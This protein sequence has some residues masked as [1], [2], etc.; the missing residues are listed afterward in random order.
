MRHLGW[1]G[2]G[3]LVAAALMAC[4][5]EELHEKPWLYINRDPWNM[6][7]AFVGARPQDSIYMENQGLEP[8]VLTSV[9]LSGSGAFS[10]LPQQVNMEDGGIIT[11]PTA[12]TIEPRKRS[13]L[14]LIFNP[15]R[16][17]VFT[18][19][20]TITSNA[21]NA[22]TKVVDVRARACPADGGPCPDGGT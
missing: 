11:N 2:A 21:E 20:V 6:D 7:P 12:M 15:P 8:L 4:P 17:G 14:T 10:K 16:E 22:P 1:L 3:A 5:G 18:G 13:Y 9:D 19:Q